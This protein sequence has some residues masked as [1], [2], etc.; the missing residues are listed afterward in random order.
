MAL[1]HHSKRVANQKRL[2]ARIIHQSRK[3]RIITGEHRN[4]LARRLHFFQRCYRNHSSTLFFFL[5]TNLIVGHILLCGSTPHY[6]LS[7][8]EVSK[9]LK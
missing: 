4:L 8:G 6:T 5:S 9:R 7:D 1:N 2:N 3:R